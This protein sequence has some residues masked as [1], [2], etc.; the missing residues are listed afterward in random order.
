MY[1]TGL[2]TVNDKRWERLFGFPKRS[3]EG[4]NGQEH[5]DLAL[6]IQQFI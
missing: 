2:R 1:A 4:E 6:A 5:C 3:Q